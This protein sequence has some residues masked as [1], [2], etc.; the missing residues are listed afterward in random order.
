MTFA[1]PR[2]PSAFD[3]LRWMA[4][5]LRAEILQFEFDYPIEVVAA[6]GP[7]DSLHY[8]VHSTRLFFDAMQVDDD[9]VPVQHSRHF[10]RAYN[11]AYVAWYGLTKLESHLRGGDQA[12]MAAFLRQVDWLECTAVTRADGAIIWPYNFDWLEGS[13]LLKAPWCSAMAQGLAI[14]ALVR[15]YRLTRRERLLELARAGV[16][17]FEQNTD[18]GGVR[19]PAREGALFEEYPAYPLARVLDGFLFGL[20]GLY[21]VAVETADARVTALWQEGLDGLAS[22]L[23]VWDYRGQWSW[24]GSHGYLC[25]PKYNALNSAL[26]ASIGRVSGRQV[27]EQYAAAW[28][29]DRLSRLARLR[30]FAVFLWT[31]NRT[32]IRHSTW[33][34]RNDREPDGTR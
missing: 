11:P 12:T 8:Y 33:R 19:T 21:D 4:G 17:V 9:G 26:L 31:K 27:I 20:L 13:A 3:S 18:A 34:R 6:A 5:A 10:G 16:A 29:P 25:P 28:R 15:G 32:R 22:T 7:K 23:P 24:Y 30:I 14:S 2:R 1:L